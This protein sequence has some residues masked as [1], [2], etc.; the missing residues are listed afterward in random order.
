MGVGVGLAAAGIDPPKGVAAVHSGYTFNP[1]L[2]GGGAGF[3]TLS[4]LMGRVRKKAPKKPEKEE[5]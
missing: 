2:A 4:V 3:M 5:E 1:Y